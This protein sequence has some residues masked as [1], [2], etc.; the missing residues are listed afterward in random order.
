MSLTLAAAGCGGGEGGVAT[1][2]T[3]APRPTIEIRVSDGDRGRPVPGARVVARR[4]GVVLDVVRADEG[5]RAL[6]PRA[7]RIVTVSAPG[8]SEARASVR[9][10]PA[11]IELYDRDLQSPEYGGGPGRNRFAAAVRAGPPDGPPA[12]TFESRTLI[13][14]P[15]VVD[16]G[17]LVVGV[18][19][20]RVYAMNSETGALL[21]ARRQR[22]AIA[23][24][25]AIAGDRVFVTSMD[26]ALTAYTRAHGTPLWQFSTDGSPV[27]TSPLVVDGLVY[28]GAWNGSVYAVDA[29][30]GAEVWRSVGAGQV[31]GSA[32]LAGDLVVVGD[33]AGHVRALDARSGAARWTYRGGRRFYGGPAVSGRTV[34]VGDVGGSVVA[35]DARTGTRRWRHRTGAYVYSSPAI[36]DGRVFIGSYSG[37][38]EALDLRTGARRW[39]FDAGGRISGSATVVGGVVYASILSRGTVGLSARTGAVRYRG[40]D[41]RYSPA[42]GAGRSLYLV[43]TRHLD[44]HPAP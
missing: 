12:W 7:T 17:L 8:M 21:W 16:A 15:P 32:A 34:V 35:L 1:Q 33:Y 36:A 4:R 41:G 22:G 40:A 3:T 27:E 14:F 29:Q 19:S 37:I 11:E 42:V 9:S 26:G 23:S 10:R 44:A 25:A 24:S 13:E 6:V 31:K 28:I 30:T 18:N 39:S 38:F 5:G 43:R 20:G 2:P